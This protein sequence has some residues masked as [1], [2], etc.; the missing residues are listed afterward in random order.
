MPLIT[1][2]LSLLFANPLTEGPVFNK[3]NGSSIE[4]TNRTNTS[5]TPESYIITEMETP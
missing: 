3:D 2:I 1:F 5:D 4:E